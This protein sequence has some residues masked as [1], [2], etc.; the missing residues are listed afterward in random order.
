MIDIRRKEMLCGQKK[1]KSAP[2]RCVEIYP[3]GLKKFQ[4]FL[5]IKKVPKSEKHRHET[6][7]LDFFQWGINLRLCAVQI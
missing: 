7:G 1:V 3:I 4:K 5:K 2:L 6:H